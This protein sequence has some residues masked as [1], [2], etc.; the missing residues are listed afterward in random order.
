MAS[1]RARVSTLPL[2][3][4]AL[5]SGVLG[6]R[7]ILTVE[8]LLQPVRDLRAAH[9]LQ[10]HELEDGAMG[11]RDFGQGPAA[12]QEGHLPRCGLLARGEA[13][14]AFF[15]L[16][17]VHAVHAQHPAGGG[18]ELAGQQR[19]GELEGDQVG[20]L[21]QP[22]RDDEGHA[23]L[24]AEDLVDEGDER[25]VVEAHPDGIAGEVLA[26]AIRDSLRHGV[27]DDDAR[28]AGDA[29]PEARVLHRRRD[30]L[31]ARRGRGQ[32]PG[33]PGAAPETARPPRSR[34]RSRDRRTAGWERG[35]G[36]G[37]FISGS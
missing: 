7:E 6:Y 24:L 26:Q 11:G 20:L 3:S 28:R 23:Q 30:R 21:A 1:A 36:G 16:P 27:L 15:D 29:Q 13:D 32:R 2:S 17:Q 10:R 12:D 19:L 25:H 22:R 4:S 18:E 9:D 33:W 14:Q 35:G 37:A 8:R 5:R 34:I 31:Q